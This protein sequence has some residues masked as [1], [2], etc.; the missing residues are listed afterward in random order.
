MATIFGKAKSYLA[1]S[2]S[3]SALKYLFLSLDELKKTNRIS[4][5]ATVYTSIWIDYRQKS[6]YNTALEY[7]LKTLKIVIATN[8]SARM[9]ECP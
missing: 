7:Y 4:E 9:L 2:E 6:D 3:N 5:F 1:R 8:D